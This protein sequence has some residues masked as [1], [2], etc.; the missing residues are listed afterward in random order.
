MTIEEIEKLINLYGNLTHNG[1]AYSQLSAQIER[2]YIEMATGAKD[3]LLQAIKQY[4]TK[5]DN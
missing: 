5:N 1:G 4:G 3:K 2:Q